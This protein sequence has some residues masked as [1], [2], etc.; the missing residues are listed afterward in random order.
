MKSK[1]FFGPL[2]LRAGWRLLVFITAIAALGMGLQYLAALLHLPK[3]LQAG[4]I[5]PG[6]ALLNESQE[7]LLSL[8]ATWFM[9]RFVD[10]QPWSFYGLPWA[11]A[12]RKLFWM[13]TLTGVIALSLQLTVM[14][15]LRVFYFGSIALP[16]AEAIKYA[17]LWAV[18]F[19]FVALAEEFLLRGFLMRVLTD[20][21]GFWPAAVLTSALFAL[22]HTGNPGES[23]IGILAV[24]VVGVF[25]CFTLRRTGNLWWAVGFHAGW[26]WAQSYFFGV[27]DSGMVAQGHLLSPSFVGN[28]ILTGGSVGPEGSILI[29]ITLGAAAFG[30]H[31]AYPNALYAR[32]TA[33]PPAEPVL[34]PEAAG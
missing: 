26:D 32:R 14:R 33:P 9:A 5:R 20:G 24:F 3:M 11:L 4:G 6:P 18:V 2:G 15:L 34:Q 12:L 27:A 17:A 19:L 16:A 1:L 30:F 7:L 29:F 8:L 21:I 31:R 25:F 28:P 22:A 13:G 23:K 10:R